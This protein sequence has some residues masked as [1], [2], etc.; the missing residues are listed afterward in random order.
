MQIECIISSLLEYY[1]EMQFILCK[2]SARRVERK[3]LAQFSFPKR[4]LFY[5][6]LVSRIVYHKQLRSHNMFAGGVV[7]VVDV[8]NLSA[9]ILCRCGR[10]RGDSVRRFADVRH[11]KLR[12]CG[13]RRN[14]P[15]HT[16]RYNRS[17]AR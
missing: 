6:E 9:L 13:F 16:Y 11:T 17:E 4:R 12:N 8:I 1:A 2:D 5:H 14:P 15:L 3:E 7:Y 10:A